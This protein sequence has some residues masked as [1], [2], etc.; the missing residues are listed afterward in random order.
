MAKKKS[1][2]SKRGLSL[3]NYEHDGPVTYEPLI[4]QDARSKKDPSLDFLRG[5][6][7]GHALRSGSQV[8]DYMQ[9]KRYCK[10]KAWKLDWFGKEDLENLA[11]YAPEGLAEDKDFVNRIE[12][13]R[14]DYYYSLW[15][16]ASL[17]ELNPYKRVSELQKRLRNFLELERYLKDQRL[18]L[19]YLAWKVC[20]PDSMEQI[21]DS[22]KRLNLLLEAA[23]SAYQPTKFKRYPEFRLAF[24][25]AYLLHLC[26]VR[27]TSS[28]DGALARL[29][30]FIIGYTE[31]P[32]DRKDS[33]VDYRHFMIPALNNLKRRLKEGPIFAY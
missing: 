6:V 28:R 32:N 19:P 12:G 7:F 11:Q 1:S 2:T 4:F 14:N 3:L 15:V 10:S 25:L 26:R 13:I 8:E 29:V 27:P 24:E 5:F 17:S 31:D 30:T 16:Q 21:Q 9:F 20:G 18:A 33:F 22:L 23:V